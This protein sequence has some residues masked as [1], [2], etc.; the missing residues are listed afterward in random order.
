ML[1]EEGILEKI[2]SFGFKTFSPWIDESY[3]TIANN[4]Q[5]LEAIKQEIDRISTLDI[6][7]LHQ[8]LIP[9]LEHNRETYGKY[10]NSR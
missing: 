1:W 8:K 10:I 6:N 3:D 7:E 4:Y 2:R 9:T 5:R